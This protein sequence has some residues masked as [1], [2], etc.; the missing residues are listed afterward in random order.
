VTHEPL[1]IAA[2][3]TLAVAQITFAIV[4][5]IRHETSERRAAARL[6]VGYINSLE[7]ENRLLRLTGPGRTRKEEHDDN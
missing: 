1:L 6:L 5:V 4:M 7:R 2:L 3:A